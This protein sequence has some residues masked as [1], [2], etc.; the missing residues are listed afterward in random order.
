[1]FSGLNILNADD[2]ITIVQNNVDQLKNLTIGSV[3]DL[4]N[5]LDLRYKKIDTDILLDKK[6]MYLMFNHH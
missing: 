2:K 4:Q 5:Q 6:K 3:S 1:M